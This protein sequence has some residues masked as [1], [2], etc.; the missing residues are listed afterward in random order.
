MYKKIGKLFENK[1]ITGKVL[2]ISGIENF[3]PFMEKKK[4]KL[5][6]VYYPKVDMQKLPF[7]DNSFDFVISDQVIEHIE[8]PIKAVDESFRV[9]KKGGIAIHATVLLTPIHKNPNDYWRFTPD[10]L[11][12]LCRN[13][14]K[15]IKVGSWGNRVALAL[16]LISDH[17]RFI[18]VYK[19]VLNPIYYLAVWNE[20]KYP[21]TTWIIARK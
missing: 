14:S 5:T 16:T 9:L 12:F 3:Y 11:K 17:L 15:I 13:Y 2:G 8:N 19:H 10:G 4:C 6:E 21:I 1:P 18:P 7:K 20:D